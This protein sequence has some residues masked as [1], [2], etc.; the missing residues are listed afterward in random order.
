MFTLHLPGQFIR[1]QSDRSNH[2]PRKSQDEFDLFKDI[3]RFDTKSN[4]HLEEQ[5]EKQRSMSRSSMPQI[6][7]ERTPQAKAA[8]DVSHLRRIIIDDLEIVFADLGVRRNTV[9]VAGQKRAY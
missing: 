8:D 6:Y 3:K 9:Q 7:E 4:E 5:F 2:E 1:Q